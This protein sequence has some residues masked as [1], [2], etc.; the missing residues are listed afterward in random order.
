MRRGRYIYTHIYSEHDASASSELR[1]VIYRHEAMATPMPGACRGRDGP[2]IIHGARET[3]ELSATEFN[4]QDPGESTMVKR[5]Q[6]LPNVDLQ[7]PVPV[8]STE[9]KHEFDQS[10]A[11][12]NEAIK[13]HDVIE[14]M[15][16]L[17]IASLAWEI[18][19]LRGY[20]TAM[21]NAGIRTALRSAITPLLPEGQEFGEKMAKANDLVRG[22]FSDPTVR[23]KVLELLNQNQQDESAIEAEGIRGSF[24]D[25]ERIVRLLAILESRRDR[26]LRQISEYRKGFA[27]RLRDTSD[28]I[29]EGKALA[30][31]DTRKSRSA[32]A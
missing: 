6:Y 4:I 20:Q 31:D 3:M 21:I 5:E 9:S 17:E 32:A 14:R 19:R 16:T 2:K 11:E 23:T 13:P 12:F 10:L 1:G 26:A 18:Q 30:V 7:L 27:Q 28:R 15:Y 22:A 29:I 25:F 8:L 24:E